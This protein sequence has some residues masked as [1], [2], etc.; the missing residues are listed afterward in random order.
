[1]A[2]GTLKV[3]TITT[4]SGSGT[5]TI[6]QS[7]ETIALGSGATA[8]GFGSDSTP[9]FRATM[10]GNQSIANETF[11]KGAFNTETWDTDSAY[12][13]STYRFTV[14]SGEAGKYCFVSKAAID[15]IDDGESITSAYYKNGSRDDLSWSTQWISQSTNGFGYVN[16]VYLVDL[17]VSDYIELYVS[18]KEGG[19]QDLSATYSFFGGFKLGGV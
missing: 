4:S 3:G 16:N 9:S 6:G 1:M 17:A 2:D 5:I 14:P 15:N 12:D 13:T 18:H 11:V 7:G 19:S 8:T 10:S